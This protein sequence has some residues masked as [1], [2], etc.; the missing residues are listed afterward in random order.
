[1]TNATNNILRSKKG[2]EFKVNNKIWQIPPLKLNI[3]EK[4]CFIPKD[5]E[6]NSDSSVELCKIVSSLEEIVAGDLYLFEN[7][8]SKSNYSERLELRKQIGY[9]QSNGGLFSTKTVAENIS[10]PLTF[11]S[12]HNEMSHK[13]KLDFFS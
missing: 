5:D 3:N 7:N 9:I 12:G 11:H 6:T 2:F 13:S 4:I 10:Y 1:M 8:I